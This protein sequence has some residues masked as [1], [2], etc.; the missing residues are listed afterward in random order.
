MAIIHTKSVIIAPKRAWLKCKLQSSREITKPTMT[1][2]ESCCAKAQTMMDTPCPFFFLRCSVSILYPILLFP[3]CN[4]TPLSIP[5]ARL[6]PSFLS[7][8]LHTLSSSSARRY[9]Y[10]PIYI[11]TFHTSEVVNIQR[12][13]PCKRYP[14]PLR[15]QP[16]WHFHNDS[17]TNANSTPQTSNS[18]PILPFCNGSFQSDISSE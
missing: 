11:L 13:T 14:S 8:V 17:F 10:S 15:N 12:G 1:S 18:T 5:R 7:L 16:D 4:L 3:L 6:L 9:R 2:G